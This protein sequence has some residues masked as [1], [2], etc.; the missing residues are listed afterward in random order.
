MCFFG[1]YIY[2][3]F[4]FPSVTISIKKIRQ[5]ISLASRSSF[6]FHSLSEKDDSVVETFSCSLKHSVL[7]CFFF[8]TS[9]NSR[10]FH[11]S[12]YLKNRLTNVTLSLIWATTIWWWSNTVKCDSKLCR[13]LRQKDVFSTTVGKIGL[14][15]ISPFYHFSFIS[16]KRLRQLWCIFILHS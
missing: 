4:S 11:F 15:D 13:H 6:A 5:I 10:S 9:S 7:V 14:E 12:Q 16:D 2:T 8:E 1:S 3:W